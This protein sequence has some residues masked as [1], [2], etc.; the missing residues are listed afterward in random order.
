[1]KSNISFKLM[2]AKLLP[3]KILFYFFH[4]HIRNSKTLITIKPKQGGIDASFPTSHNYLHTTFFRI[5]YGDE[6]PS[7]DIKLFAYVVWEC[8]C[9]FKENFPSKIELFQENL[10]L[11]SSVVRN[12]STDEILRRQVKKKFF[13]LLLNMLNRFQV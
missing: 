13:D 9:I 1:M 10:D 3:S 12:F 11:C 6:R 4:K 7:D 8:C 2:K 5:S